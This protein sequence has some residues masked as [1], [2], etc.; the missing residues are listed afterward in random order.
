MTQTTNEQAMQIAMRHHRDGQLAMAEDIYRKVLAQ[1]P[2]HANALRLLGVIAVDAGKVEAGIE[3]IRR[4]IAINPNEAEYYSNLGNALGKLGKFDD[5]IAAHRIATRLNPDYAEVHYNLANAL[6][7]NGKT[8]EAIGEYRQAIRIRPDLASPHNNLG[9]ALY[10]NGQFDEAIAACRRAIQLDPAYFEAHFNVGL[11]LQAKGQ[12]DESIAA[13]REALRLRPD[14]AEAHY[15][16]GNALHDIERFD[17]AIAA[18]RQAL[19]LK[20]DYPE[21][22]NNLGIAL[23]DNGRLE[24]ANT[25]YLEALRIRNENPPVHWNLALNYL[26]QG[27]FKDG[28]TEHEWRWKCQSFPS[29][30]PTFLRPMWDGRDLNGQTILLHAEQGFG[31]TIQFARFAPMVADRGGRV[32]LQCQAKLARLL[33]WNPQLGQIISNDGAVPEFDFHCPLLSLPLAFNTDIQSIPATT[34]YLRVDPALAKAWEDR[35]ASTPA[36]FRVGLVWAG[37]PAHKRDRQRSL[38]L[39]QFLPLAAV[40]DAAFFSLQ[41]G[42]ASNQIKD[43]PQSMKLIDLTSDLHDFAETAALIA[44][45]DLV[46]GADTAVVHLAAAI[47]KPVWLLLPSIPDWRWLM[48]REDSPWYPTM[49]LFRQTSPGDWAGVLARVTESLAMAREDSPDRP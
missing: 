20:P 40:T 24:D 22:H 9:H 29:P 17:E 28:W 39:S 14:S 35:L 31:D 48:N 18:Y 32:V 5:A 26:L 27:N 33:E 3:L 7:K 37:S 34:P 19:R 45:L 16:L 4:A 12:L 2:N 36:A 30:R 25:A 47:G 6:M 21:A 44:N 23:R 10:V 42:A 13:T 15:N 49:R 1:N 41:K 11:A 38:A 43:L 8:L 46:I